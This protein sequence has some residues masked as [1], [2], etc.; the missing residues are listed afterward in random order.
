MGKIVYLN[1][2]ICFILKLPPHVLKQELNVVLRQNIFKN[3]VG[4]LKS[5]KSFLYPYP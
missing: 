4:G 5:K 2:E 3:Q 1:L